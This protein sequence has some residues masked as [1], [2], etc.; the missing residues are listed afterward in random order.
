MLF[1]EFDHNIKI[2]YQNLR[3]NANFLQKPSI[4]KSKLFLLAFI[5]TALCLV[6]FISLLIFI[7]NNAGSCLHIFACEEEVEYKSFCVKDGSQYCCGGYKEET[8]SCGRF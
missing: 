3:T 5:L 2:I 8:Y 1:R 4:F 7:F 6:S